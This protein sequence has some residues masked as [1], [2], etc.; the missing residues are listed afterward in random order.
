M[1]LDGRLLRKHAI[2]VYSYTT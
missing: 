1:M 2:K